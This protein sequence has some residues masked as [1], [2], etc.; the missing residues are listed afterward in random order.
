VLQSTLH[1]ETTH[2]YDGLLIFRRPANQSRQKLGTVI[3][4]DGESLLQNFT[5]EFALMLPGKVDQ[6]PS[7]ACKRQNGASATQPMRPEPKKII[8]RLCDFTGV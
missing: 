2:A 3:P 7:H 8:V 1:P 4:V 5:L 6:I